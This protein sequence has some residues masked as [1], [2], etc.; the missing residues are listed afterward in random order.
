MK[1]FCE[2]HILAFLKAWNNTSP[3][4]QSLSTYFRAHKSLGSHDRKEIGEAIYTLIRWKSLFDHLDPSGSY[5]LR[6]HLLGLHPIAEWINEPSV[7]EHARLGLSEF[8]L[9]ELTR[10]YGAKAKS[11]AS[12]LNSAATVTIRT[13]LL[14]TT[15]EKLLAI[16]E[17]KF[18][19]TPSTNTTTAILFSKREPLFSLPEFKQGLFEVQDEGSQRLSDLVAAKSGDRVLDYCSGSG[20]KTLAIAPKMCGK[21]ELYLHDIRAHALKEATVRLRRA[22]V[23][24]AQVLIAGHPTLKKLFGKMDWVL[25]DV[26]C[27][28]TGT[29]R[30]NPDM[31]WKIDAEMIERLVEEQRTI[32]AQAVRYAKN[33]AN[34]VYATCSILPQENE[35]Q[36]QHFLS[37]LPIV[38]EKELKI[39]PEQGGC[40][41]FYGVVFRKSKIE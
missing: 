21:G 14:K 36:V 31:K 20:G 8:L 27:S 4:D 32:F 1:S 35:E 37:T 19:V 18:S 40:D 7:P 11:I 9:D 24:N 34:I 26:P 15:R 28:G 10:C 17:P 33:G 2:T 12:I 13:N 23:Q 3:L 25:A 38:K 41:G 6:L 16:L 30:R 29:L 22:G 5:S 39:L